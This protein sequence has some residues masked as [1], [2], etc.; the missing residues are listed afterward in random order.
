MLTHGLSIKPSIQKL[1]HEKAK[2]SMDLL[3]QVLARFDNRACISMY[4]KAE[5]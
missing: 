5:H 2:L 1:W 3:R 4:L